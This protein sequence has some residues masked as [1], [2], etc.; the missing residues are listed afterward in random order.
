MPFFF[1]QLPSYNSWKWELTRAEQEKIS[2]KLKNVS[3]VC[4]IDTGEENDVHRAA[5]LKSAGGSLRRPLLGAEKSSRR[6]AQ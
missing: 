2:K 3:M 6:C 1:V 4:A 5:R